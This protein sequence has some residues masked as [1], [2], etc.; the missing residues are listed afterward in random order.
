MATLDKFS[1]PC[2]TGR[3][4]KGLKTQMLIITFSLSTYGLALAQNSKS[5]QTSNAQFAEQ[6]IKK[7]TIIKDA[8]KRAKC[9]ETIVRSNAKVQETASETKP[10]VTT[11]SSLNDNKY[12]PELKSTIDE[13]E[14]LP[15]TKDEYESKV[16]YAN[17]IKGL[18]D[19]Y[20]GQK[21]VINAPCNM[22]VSDRESILS[23]GSKS[24][25]A[26]DAEK[27]DVVVAFSKESTGGILNRGGKIVFPSLYYSFIPVEPPLT[28]PSKYNARNGLGASVEVMK[29]TKK[30]IGVAILYRGINPFLVDTSDF[31]AAGYARNNAAKPDAATFHIK[32]TSDEAKATLSGCVVTLKVSSVL[33]ETYE[34]MTTHK[35]KMSSILVHDTEE[36]KPTMASPIHTVNE[37]IALPVRLHEIELRTND[38][39]L[40]FSEKID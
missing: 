30:S 37:Q 31:N 34:M 20:T 8:D 22:K 36:T 33:S 17:R 15:I 10:I 19:K 5:S 4:T 9:F 23:S 7:C 6:Q 12:S 27:G 13:I 3:F 21:F 1:I 24:L 18:Y 28:E 16:D 39:R 32:M 26:Y 11:K 40:I 35:L 25:V 38:N 14:A 29:F 2:R